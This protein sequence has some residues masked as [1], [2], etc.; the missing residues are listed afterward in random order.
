MKLAQQSHEHNYLISSAE[1]VKLFTTVWYQIWKKLKPQTV[2]RLQRSVFLNWGQFD[3][4]QH[5]IAVLFCL[6]IV[7]SHEINNLNR[8]IICSPTCNC[9]WTRG[10]LCARRLRVALGGL[11]WRA[12]HQHEQLGDRQPQRPTDRQVTKGHEHTAAILY[13]TPNFPW[14]WK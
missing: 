12:Q 8:H 5:I 7:V 9:T 10:F 13:L 11:L 6:L 3:T 4:L 14:K 1:L 2:A